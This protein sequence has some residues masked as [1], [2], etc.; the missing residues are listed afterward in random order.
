MDP[1][2]F[3][4]ERLGIGDWPRTDCV[5]ESPIDLDIW[6]SLTDEGSVLQDPICL[7]G[8]GRQEQ[9]RTLA[10]RSR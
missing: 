9:G 7:A 6:L 3:A 2:T 5:S 4:V 1:R 10:R 8:G